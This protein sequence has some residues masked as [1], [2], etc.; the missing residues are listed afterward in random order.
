MN[1]KGQEMFPV[2]GLGSSHIPSS[3]PPRKESIKQETSSPPTTES[4]PNKTQNISRQATLA[5][6]HSRRLVP[7]KSD[8]KDYGEDEDLIPERK[9]EKYS[10]DARDRRTC[11][12]NRIQCQIYALEAKWKQSKIRPNFKELAQIISS[13]GEMAAGN[14]YEQAILAYDYLHDNLKEAGVTLDIA[15]LKPPG[16]HNIVTI[17]QP[18]NS[19]GIY[20]KEFSDW[21]EDA[22]VVDPWAKIACPAREYPKEWV[23]KMTK[24]AGRGLKVNEESPL[25]R[26]WVNSINEHEKISRL[27]A[28]PVQ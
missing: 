3:T 13:K 14:C 10:E 17:N 5:V 20:P 24:W 22:F 12:L 19:E 7:L 1:R 18:K 21:N 26:E 8:N 28:F 25:K 4:P 16:N 6:L 27:N 9:S 2:I 23:E 11:A 15:S